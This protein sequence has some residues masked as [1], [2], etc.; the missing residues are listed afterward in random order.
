MKKLI[1]F[2]IT[3]SLLFFSCERIIKTESPNYIADITINFQKQKYDYLK[4]NIIPKILN[5][6]ITSD[7]YLYFNQEITPEGILKE[8]SKYIVI[9]KKD[10]DGT[11][12][13]IES[14]N[15]FKMPLNKENLT[16][17]E[18]DSSNFFFYESQ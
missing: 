17:I 12:T 6:E 1:S 5:K 9:Y 10:V 7:Y 14:N 18:T 3:I 2:L 4:K 15:A 8:I 16:I 11:I 13:I